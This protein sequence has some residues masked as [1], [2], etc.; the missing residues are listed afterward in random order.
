MQATMPLLGIRQSREGFKDEDKKCLII[1]MVLLNGASGWRKMF[2]TLGQ[3]SPGTTSSAATFVMV[4]FP[5]LNNRR[6]QRFEKPK[7]ILIIA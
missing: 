5:D 1:H 7:G 2:S 6:P 4:L 3:C